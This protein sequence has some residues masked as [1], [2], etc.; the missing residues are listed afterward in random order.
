MLNNRMKDLRKER[1]MSLQELAKIV[2]KSA[3]TISRY[4]NNQVDK[5]D[6]D[7]I[8]KIA[9]ALDTSSAYLLDMTDDDHYISEVKASKYLTEEGLRSILVVDDDMAPEMPEGSCV[10][11][12]DFDSSDELSIGS[13]YYIEFDNKKCFRMAVDDHVDGLGF[14]PINMS[15]RRIAYDEDYVNIIGKAVSMKVFFEDGSNYM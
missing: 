12:R 8:E 3:S 2:N 15:E 4:E 7:L 11:I 9:D 13:L 6:L 5:L 14:L 10:Q 1:L